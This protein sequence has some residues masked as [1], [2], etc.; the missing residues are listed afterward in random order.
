MTC[1][2]IEGVRMANRILLLPLEGPGTCSCCACPESK[3]RAQ[4]E[5]LFNFT[6]AEMVKFVIPAITR[7]AGSRN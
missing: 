4:V 6:Q 7:S 5:M 3:I 1:S 2:G